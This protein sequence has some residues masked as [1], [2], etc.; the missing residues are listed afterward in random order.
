M[1]LLLHI[2]ETEGDSMNINELARRYENVR[3]RTKR[4]SAIQI[5]DYENML[6]ECCRE[7]LVLNEN[8]ICLK[9]AKCS[10]TIVGLDLKMRTY[11][12]GGASISGTLHS[13]SFEPL[14]EKKG[15]NK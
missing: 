11:S 13:V 2:Y 8:M 3:N 14:D 15:K 12:S 10:V 4:H 9:L 6:I 1:A 5:M 7:I